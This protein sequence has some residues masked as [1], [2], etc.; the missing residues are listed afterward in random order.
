MPLTT[1]AYTCMYMYVTYFQ[2]GTFS[3]PPP[4]CNRLLFHCFVQ[5]VNEIHYLRSLIIALPGYRLPIQNGEM[6]SDRM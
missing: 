4:K 6:A 3:H 2:K 5:E 1:D